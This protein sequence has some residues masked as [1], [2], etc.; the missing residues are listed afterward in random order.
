MDEETVDPPKRFFKSNFLLPLRAEDEAEVTNPED[1]AEGEE[2]DN[3][4]TSLEIA[5]G[6]EVVAANTLRSTSSLP[7]PSPSDQCP[8][9]FLPVFLA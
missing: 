4:V 1:L 8:S 5:L 9:P 2:T 7:S 6:F 3:A